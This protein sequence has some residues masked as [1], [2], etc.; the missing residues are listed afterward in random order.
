MHLH[1]VISPSYMY[2]VLLLMTSLIR[3][4]VPLPELDECISTPCLN[5]GICQD[6]LSS[7]N[8]ACRD[9]YAGILCEIRESTYL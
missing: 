8:C 9:G 1:P 4:H 2:M 6:G 3:L 5:G 7:F